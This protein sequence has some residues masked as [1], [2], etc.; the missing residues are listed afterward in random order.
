MVLRQAVLRHRHAFEFRIHNPQVGSL[1]DQVPVTNGLTG[2]GRAGSRLSGTY[3]GGSGFEDA[4]MKS[5]GPRLG[6][7]PLLTTILHH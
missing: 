1:A 7:R 6:K 5:G 2:N 4:K 3:R